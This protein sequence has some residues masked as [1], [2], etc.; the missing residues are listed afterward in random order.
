MTSTA[1][2][3]GDDD[4]KVAAAAAAAPARA[5][6]DPA[7]SS[8]PPPRPL[9]R[10]PPAA[11]A[12]LPRPRRRPLRVKVVT[13]G[14][15][16]AGKSC[17]VKRYCEGRFAGPR[18]VPTIGA[19]YGVKP[20]AFF[21][22]AATARASS[23][24]G[25]ASGG[26]GGEGGGGDGTGQQ[27]SSSSIESGSSS[28]GGDDGAPYE[29]RVGF[30]DL[31]GPGEYAEARAELYGGAQAA[32]LVLDVCSR[33]SFEALGAW[34]EELRRCGG[35]G[36]GGGGGI[37]SGGARCSVVVTG[38]KADAAESA[39]RVSP[40]EARAW[41]E[42]RALPYFEVRREQARCFRS[43]GGVLRGGGDVVDRLVLGAK[44]NALLNN[45]TKKT[46]ARSLR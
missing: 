44:K 31:A 19:D 4:D 7:A 22:T 12:A 16:A 46:N 38:T 28:G 29:V 1:G 8:P 24:Q 20:V 11:C 25:A 30:W 6:Q 5:A 18:Y 42:S 2:F 3:D 23:E 33:A 39:R 37:G 35:S 27:D 36:G 15:T 10:Q 13:L 45:K 9:P 26:G 43:E 17:L 41:A 21:P 40:A 14:A 32:L 34:L